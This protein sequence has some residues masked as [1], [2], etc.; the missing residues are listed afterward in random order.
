MRVLQRE[1]IV[2]A[3]NPRHFGRTRTCIYFSSN[4][5]NFDFKKRQWKAKVT[6]IR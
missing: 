1:T 6:T 5:D 2:V 3:Q 4:R